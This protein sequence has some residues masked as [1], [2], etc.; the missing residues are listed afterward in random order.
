[1]I[2]PANHTTEERRDGS[3]EVKLVQN[4]RHPLQIRIYGF[5]EYVGV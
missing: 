2:L 4:G 1:M 5:K 3:S